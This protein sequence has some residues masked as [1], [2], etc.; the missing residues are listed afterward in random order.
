MLTMKQAQEMLSFYREMFTVARLIDRKSIEKVLKN[1]PMLAENGVP[2]SCAGG[3]WKLLPCK[4]CVV[5]RAF[6]KKTRQT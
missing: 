2:C 6:Q 1:Q 5:T 4:Y 3:A